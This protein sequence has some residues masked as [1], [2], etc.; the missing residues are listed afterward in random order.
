MKEFLSALSACARGERLPFTLVLRDPL[1]NSFVS[2]PLGSFLPPEA[3][4]ALT[5]EDFDRSFEE[6]RR[7]TM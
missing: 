4:S 2:A 1:G 3:D 6:V 7:V 5:F